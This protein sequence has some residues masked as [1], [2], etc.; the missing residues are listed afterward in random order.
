MIW[1]FSRSLVSRK[2]L[3]WEVRLMGRVQTKRSIFSR[4]ESKSFYFIFAQWHL[5]SW[6]TSSGDHI[7][8]QMFVHLWMLYFW[9]GL[10]SIQ[11]DSTLLIANVMAKIKT[12]AKW[13]SNSAKSTEW[14]F[15]LEGNVTLMDTG[16]R[17]WAAWASACL[18]AGRDRS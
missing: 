11:L 13:Y 18:G 3:S 7:L 17:W 6:F 4:F 9:Y 8:T 15:L 5:N 12:L 1:K 14:S 2:T 10:P 16:W